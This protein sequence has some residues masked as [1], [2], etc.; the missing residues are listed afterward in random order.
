[1]GVLRWGQE[2]GQFCFLLSCGDEGNGMPHGTEWVPRGSTQT[3]LG[4][5]YSLGK[6]CERR[7]YHCVQLFVQEVTC[8]SL[9]V[10]V[11]K[12]LSG[13]WRATGLNIISG[14]VW[15]LI[16]HYFWECLWRCFQKGWA[17]EKVNWPKQM[18]PC[19]V[20]RHHPIQSLK[21]LNLSLTAKAEISSCPQCSWF[22][23]LHSWPGI[24][25]TSA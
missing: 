9:D 18:A 21:G 5:G 22:S 11:V 15:W 2:K 25:T 12:F 4:K 24:Y 20:G 16:K 14:C 13:P 3:S 23:E 8:F 1:M 10:V 19:S 7:Y 6:T 17:F